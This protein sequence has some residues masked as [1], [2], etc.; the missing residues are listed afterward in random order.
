MFSQ[1]IAYSL[2]PDTFLYEGRL[3]SPVGVPITTAHSFRFS[4]WNSEDF[5]LTDVD[6]LGQIDITSPTYSGWQEVQT[7]T[8]NS[9][10]T[11]SIK[12][13]SI[14][15]LP[16]LNPLLN[17]YLQVELKASADPDTSYELLDVTGDNGLDAVDRKE[18][19]STPYSKLGDYSIA[20]LNESFVIDFDNTVENNATGDIKISFGQSLGKFLTYDFDN[21]SFIFNDNLNIQGDL[22]VD[23]AIISGS[24]QV[25]ITDS[26]GN[27]D[28][29]T[30]QSDSIKDEALN[31]GSALG[32]IDGS[33]IPLID[34][35]TYSNGL[36]VQEVLEDLDSE[37]SNINSSQSNISG[38]NQNLFTLDAD[39]TGGDVGLQFG[40]TLSKQLFW[41]S[42]NNI[43][44]FNDDLLVDGNLITSGEIFVGSSQ[45]Q[46]TDSFGYI[47]GNS[48][49]T[50][51]INDTSL[52]FGFGPN[53]IS[54]EDILTSNSNGYTNATNLEEFV[55]EIGLIMYERFS[56][57][58]VSGGL[59]SD[60]GA[61]T[62]DISAGV[63]HINYNTV[64]NQRITWPSFA[65]FVLPFN[66][67]NYI[68]IDSNSAV[69]IS[70][71]PPI[72]GSKI[73]LGYAYTV[74]A[75]SDIGTIAPIRSYVGDFEHRV[76]S[77]LDM[78]IGPISPSGNIASEIPATLGLQ[79]SSGKIYN[80]LNLFNTNDTNTF[81]KWYNTAD[82]GWLPDVNGLNSVNTKHYNDA[83]KNSVNILSGTSFFTNGST[84][85]SGIGTAYISQV[86]VGDYVY[87]QADG[88]NYKTLVQSIDSNTQLTLGYIYLGAGGSATAISDKS[89]R[90][91][92]SSYWKKDLLVRDMNGIVHYVYSQNQYATEDLAKESANPVIPQA[93]SNSGVIYLAS[94]VT[95][96]GDTD[97]SGSLSDLRPNFQ[98]VFGYGTYGTVGTVADHGSLLGLGDDDH[99]QY[100][101][102]DGSDQMEG[103]LQMNSNNILD[104]TIDADLNDIKNISISSLQDRNKSIK[105]KPAYTNLVI[106]KDGTSNNVT[107]KQGNDNLNGI[108][109]F[110]LSSNKSSLN[111]IDL[112]VSVQLPDD[113]VSFQAIP[114]QLNLKSQSILDTENKIDLTLLDSLKSSVSLSNAT[115]LHSSLADTWILKNIGITGSP[116]F[117]PGSFITLNIKLQSKSQNKV[118]L[119]DINI[120][121][122]GK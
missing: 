86:E 108:Q 71:L 8:P 12:L 30:L 19:S 75:N 23:G 50:D 105:I 29:A 52:D 120:N 5:L 41:D 107:L 21:T 13:G 87:L 4:F 91:L 57:G 3:L 24:S 37:L 39:D 58:L 106:N 96:V 90:K 31:F 117:T 47:D 102:T 95:Q 61:N 112:I 94:I 99:P 65:G 68:Y 121:Y 54:A 6:V 34:N 98:R 84:T 28:G 32:Q 74:Q 56:T 1:N 25:Q 118:Y 100:F 83:S 97:L 82:F 22:T 85:V 9:N 40:S 80:N 53:Q 2:T 111:D 78:A 27:L 79:V 114:I 44:T 42:A 122:I 88:R 67:D 49:Q 89:L 14:V 35:F 109:Y 17:K 119:S 116:T 103:D 59:I 63:G 55:E 110:V 60:A 113:F 104:A 20:T 48:I 115:N 93:I 36:Q 72:T 43:F 66:G 101:N 15:P 10:G 92:Q 46:L 51:S 45:V 11:F 18:L 64:K 7:I 70:Q 16:V 81:T 76:Q 33:D 69:S 77:F 73:F 26:F 62:I 38:T